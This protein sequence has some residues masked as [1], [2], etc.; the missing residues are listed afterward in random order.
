VSIS[1]NPNTF[2]IYP[3]AFRKTQMPSEFIREHSGKPECLRNLS[4][5]ISENPNASGIYPRAFRKI[6]MPKDD[7]IMLAEKYV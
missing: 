4:A 5:S 3:Q 6:Q 1:E 2:G 7:L